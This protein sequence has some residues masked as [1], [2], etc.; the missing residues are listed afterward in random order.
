MSSEKEEFDRFIERM[1]KIRDLSSPPIY[2]VDDENEYSNRLRENFK[3]IGQLAS[4]NRRM[5]DEVLYPLLEPE[6][7]LTEEVSK[8]INAFSQ[9]LL[10]IAADF[11]DYENLDLPIMNLIGEKLVHD[12]FADG[13][14]EE[15]INRMDS[16]IVSNYSMMNM[17]ERITANPAISKKFKDRGLQIVLF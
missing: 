2:D 1:S 6:R 13:T 9:K 16:A 15:Q 11:T 4:E 8:Q 12:A 17:T 7:Q 3:T 10:S 5:L 14:I